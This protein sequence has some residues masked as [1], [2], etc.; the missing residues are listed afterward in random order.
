MGTDL[1]GNALFMAC[2][3]SRLTFKKKKLFRSFRDMNYCTKFPNLYLQVRLVRYN[4]F[5]RAVAL[6]EFLNGGGF[7]GQRI[8]SM[9]VTHFRAFLV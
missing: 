7:L 2:K 3:Q 5:G 9:T 1:P 6:P 4:S 8:Q